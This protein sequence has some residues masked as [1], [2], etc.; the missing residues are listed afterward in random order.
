M[1]EIFSSFFLIGALQAAFTF[2]FLIHVLLIAIADTEDSLLA[3]LSGM[4]RHLIM[5]PSTKYFL[6]PYRKPTEKDIKNDPALV[7]NKY[8]TN[9]PFEMQISTFF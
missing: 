8:S 9:K 6:V 5:H 7:G 2:L 4:N 3:R 1:R